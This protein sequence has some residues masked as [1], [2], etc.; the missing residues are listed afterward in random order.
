MINLDTSK[1]LLAF[2]KEYRNRAF[3]I[4]A[5][6]LG[7]AMLMQGPQHVEGTDG[8]DHMECLV[9]GSAGRVTFGSGGLVEDVEEINHGDGCAYAAYE[10]AREEIR[11]N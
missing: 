4:S 2:R 5:M 3:I 8:Y 7:E 11:F 1:V 6:D 9:C 10:K